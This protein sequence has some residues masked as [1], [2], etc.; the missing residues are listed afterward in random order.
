MAEPGGRD[1]PPDSPSVQCWERIRSCLFRSDIVDGGGRSPLSFGTHMN[2]PLTVALWVLRRLPSEQIPQMATNWLAAGLDSPSLRQLAAVSEP[3]M[4]DVG[5]VFERALTELG[6]VTPKKQEA[7]MYL[8][9]HY[10]QQIVDGTVSPY[11]GARK[12]WWEVSNEVERPSQLLLSFVGAASELDDLPERTVQ[13]GNDRQ[14]YARELE[15]MIVSSARE[16]LTGEPNQA[17]QATTAT[18]LDIDHCR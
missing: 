17:R 9:R 11:D 13:D 14:T 7:L 6:I 1:E 15:D 18:R 5:P 8:A 12:L 16:L 2:R 4:S 3:V 10:A